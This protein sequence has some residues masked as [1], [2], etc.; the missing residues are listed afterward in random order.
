MSGNKLCAKTEIITKLD[1]FWLGK[2][3]LVLCELLFSIS[4]DFTWI[5]MGSSVGIVLCSKSRAFRVAESSSVLYLLDRSKSDHRE[6][7]TSASS[8]S[9]H[10]HVH[11]ELTLTFLDAHGQETGSLVVQLLE[12]TA[13]ADETAVGSTCQELPT[14]PPVLEPIEDSGDTV[15]DSLRQVVDKIKL[16]A[17]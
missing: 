12:P 4:H 6:A 17:N 14:T 3:T 11:L 9:P 2:H 13:R 1:V 10:I 5:Y 7:A 15:L 16:A 8:P